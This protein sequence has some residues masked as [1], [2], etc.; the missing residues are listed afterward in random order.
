M[1]K[2]IAQI[3][4]GRANQVSGHKQ[5]PQQLYALLTTIGFT[6]I[7]ITRVNC[8][9][10]ENWTLRQEINGSNGGKLKSSKLQAQNRL[11]IL[12]NQAK[13][14]QFAQVRCQKWLT[15]SWQQRLQEWHDERRNRKGWPTHKTQTRLFTKRTWGQLH[16]KPQAKVPLWCTNHPCTIC[17]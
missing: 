11:Q 15:M 4:D 13:M 14:S 16:G 5:R 1:S 10:I 8:T 6:D 12:D 3:N 7:A 9:V 17:L 2:G